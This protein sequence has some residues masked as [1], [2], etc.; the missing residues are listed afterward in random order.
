MDLNRNRNKGSLEF[1]FTDTP[2][3]SAARRCKI[4]AATPGSPSPSLLWAIVCKYC[5][6]LYQ[7]HNR[8]RS[9]DDGF[10]CEH[11]FKRISD[12]VDQIN[13]IPDATDLSASKGSTRADEQAVS[14]FT[15]I[16]TALVELRASIERSNALDEIR[17]AGIFEKVASIISE[18]LAKNVQCLQ[19]SQACMK[20]K[21]LA[22]D[23]STQTE[24]IETALPK[25]L[26]NSPQSHSFQ[27]LSQGCDTSKLIQEEHKT[28]RTP[29]DARPYPRQQRV[30]KYSK[31]SVRT[32]KKRISESSTDLPVKSVLIAG[33]S[34]AD[35]LGKTVCT[36]LGEDPRCYVASQAGAMLSQI[37]AN[38]RRHVALYSR[39]LSD[40]LII[41]HAGLDDI[42]R[43]PDSIDV[44]AIWSSIEKQLDELV[45][46]CS[47]KL[48][49]L[50]VCSVPV[51]AKGPGRDRRTDCQYINA[52]MEA[53]FKSTEVLFRDFSYV[54]RTSA[55]MHADGVHFTRRGT[56]MLARPIAREAA[57]FLGIYANVWQRTKTP[58]T[59][60]AVPGGAAEPPVKV[61]SG[62]NPFLFLNR[63][64]PPLPP[65][66]PANFLVPQFSE[67]QTTPNRPLHS[68]P[69]PCSRS[70]VQPPAVWLDQLRAFPPILPQPES[71][72]QYP[73]EH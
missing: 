49:R 15:D 62:T 61:N 28:E 23:A 26:S 6:G 40:Q 2:G 5:N 25:G 73:P 50:I 51:V 16:K 66:P 4:F 34:N 71:I 14:D 24:F 44:S 29:D 45:I 65:K 59:V 9:D 43:S 30:G 39:G 64:P 55:A 67:E 1:S 35:R 38:I 53:K 47:E 19:N 27:S 20:E 36:M 31:A 70:A 48:I 63:P 72:P 68:K 11:C 58:K 54:E 41:L 42:L 18:A 52:K 22:S 7:Q 46:F 57:N 56:E 10:V 3:P 21:F 33:G 69:F 8:Q 17:F 13:R 60:V 32:Q 37:V 12:E